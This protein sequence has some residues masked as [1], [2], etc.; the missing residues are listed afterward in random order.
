MQPLARRLWDRR[1]QRRLFNLLGRLG[2]GADFFCGSGGDGGRRQVLSA[3]T[4]AFV[5]TTGVTAAGALT[6][7]GT[8]FDCCFLAHFALS[9]AGIKGINYIN[10]LY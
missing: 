2:F 8:G 9:S 6:S 5:S 1:F 10:T 4:G 3:V 7:S